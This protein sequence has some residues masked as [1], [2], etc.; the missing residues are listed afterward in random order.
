MRLFVGGIGCVLIGLWW[1]V[2]GLTGGFMDRIIGGLVWKG[3]LLTTAGAALT[4][5]GY[6][7][8]TDRR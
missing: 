4:Y 6:R 2:D 8:M 1:L 3:A 5:Y 7:I